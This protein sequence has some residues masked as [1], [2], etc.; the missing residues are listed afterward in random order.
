MKMQFP[1]VD[2]RAALR[3]LSGGFALCTVLVLA[4][5]GG[6]SECPSSPPF[7]GDSNVGSC[8]SGGGSTTPT[9]ADLSLALSAR[10]LPNDGTSTI[11]ATVT[12]VDANGTTLPDIPVTIRVDNGATSTPS[13]TAT[14]DKGVVTSDI[15]AGADRANRTISV[16][17]ISGGLSRTATFQV[18][19][20]SLS[21]TPL[22]AVIEPGAAGQVVFQLA[23]ISGSGSAMSGQTIVV[24]GVDGV[25]V[26]GSTDDSGKYTY[27]Y[28]APSAT[29]SVS[30]KATAG[31]VSN[32]QTVLVQASGS[33]AIPPAAIAVQS[34]SLAG[35]PSVVAANTD[36]T[37]NQS[38]LRALFL[39]A[40]NTPVK[41]VRVR[42]D[43]AGDLNNI[44]GTISSGTNLVYSDASGIATTSYVPGSRFSPTD[45]LTVRAC[46]SATDF[47]VGACPNETMVP[48]IPTRTTLTV[49]SQPLS[50]SIGTDALIEVV[51]QTYVKRYTV[52]VVDSS[53]LA[54]GGVLISPSIDLQQYFK[55]QWVV[56]GDKWAKV[57]R[58]SCDNED[59]NRN[60]VLQTYANGVNE[61]AN[62]TGFIEPRKAD[63][64]ISFEGSNTTDGNG[65][66]ELKITYPQNVGSW[67]KFNIQVAASGV[68]GTEGRTNFTGILPVLADAI[69]DPAKEPPFA[70][71]P[72]GTA[73]G[74]NISVEYPAGSNQFVSLCTNPN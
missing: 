64:A 4:A 6:D 68:A 20:A 72:Y 10:T 74:D 27:S 35:S 60:G 46:W 70:V 11:K 14:D 16:T 7:E 57:T 41:N 38:E 39:G 23:D 13:G 73:V 44:G 43:L 25:E 26:T 67:L 18:T 65:Q 56:Q 51:G 32:T 59:L 24:N 1:G 40:G 63:V 53:G 21:G 55:G 5:C 58:A 3:R 48:A 36:S 42:F 12:A 37:S 17:A 52:Q 22:P 19:G 49:I 33:G 62:A 66:V 28:T 47:P 71:S 30:V 9:A 29:G 31:G 8:A 34:A 54:K 69:S 45:G 50:V 61:D 15:G 2:A